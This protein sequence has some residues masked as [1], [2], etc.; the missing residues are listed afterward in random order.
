MQP[1]GDIDFDGIELKDTAITEEME[2]LVDQEDYRYYYVDPK[3]KHPDILDKYIPEDWTVFFNHGKNDKERMIFPEEGPYLEDEEKKYDE[4]KEFEEK[5]GDPLPT[6]LTKR[7]IMRF[8]SANHWKIKPTY[9]NILQ[10]LKWRE[11][12]KPIVLKEIHKRML[13]IGYMYIHGRDKCLRPICLGNMS[14]V[15]DLDV[16]IQEACYINWFMCFY[17]IENLM[18]RGKVE[19]WILVMDLNG[20][21]LSKLPTKTLKQIMTECQDHLKCRIRMAFYFNVTFGL[22]AIWQLVSPFID[23]MIKHKMVMKGD[24][25]DPLLGELVHPSQLEKKYGGDAEDVTDF[26][27]PYCPSDEYGVQE[28]SLH[29]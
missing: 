8:L 19:N 13:D 3:V 15:N 17:L 26:W 27:P 6:S 1:G 24:A 10:H 12:I 23:K 20:L 21:S 22:R 18:V 11:G 4:F 14:I 29:S 7:R 2:E 28:H 9:Q 16:D 5:S 25:N